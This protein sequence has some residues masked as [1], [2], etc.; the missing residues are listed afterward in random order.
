M[1]FYIGNFVAH[2]VRQEFHIDD[3]VI[4]ADDRYVYQDGEVYELATQTSSGATANVSNP[5][6]GIRKMAVFNIG[7]QLGVI[8]G[9]WAEADSFELLA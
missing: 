7:G 1:S 9:K 6:A 3:T 5:V 2:P 4:P 8:G